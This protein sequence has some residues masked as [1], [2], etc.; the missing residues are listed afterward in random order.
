MALRGMVA[1][2]NFRRMA[3]DQFQ[4]VEVGN[5]FEVRK[6]GVG[7]R[8]FLERSAAEKYASDP[9]CRAWCESGESG[10]R[11]AGATLH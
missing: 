6:N 3:E 10:M 11:E 4:I 2:A 5:W 1:R 8:A 7:V 9:A